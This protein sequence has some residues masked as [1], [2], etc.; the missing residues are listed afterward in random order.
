[1]PSKELTQFQSSLKNKQI[2]YNFSNSSI[3]GTLSLEVTHQDMSMPIGIL[4]Y[5]WVGNTTLEILYSFIIEDGRRCG[6]RTFMHKVLIDAYPS[7]NKIIT[8]SGNKFSKPW[9]IKTGFKENKDGDWV[10]QI[11]K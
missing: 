3:P 5:K 6:V 10:Y 11:K 9:L 7:A 8:A 2:D 1:M 4:W